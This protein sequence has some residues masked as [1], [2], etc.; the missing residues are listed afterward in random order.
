MSARQ[1]TEYQA[2]ELVAGPIGSRY[3][4]E[5]LAN[6]HEELQS[7]KQVLMAVNMK[8]PEEAPPVIH[9]PRPGEFGLEEDEGE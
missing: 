2:Y 7:L 3:S 6:I 8:D 1:L 5:A 4:E 9:Y